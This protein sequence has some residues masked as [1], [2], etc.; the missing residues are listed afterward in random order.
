MEDLVARLRAADRLITQRSL[1]FAHADISV[2]AVPDVIAF[3]G[4]EAPAIIDWKVH[5]FG[6]RDAWLQL[7][8]VNA[9]TPA[10]RRTT[11]NFAQQFRTRLT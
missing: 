10:A 9:F 8:G 5:A 7:A 2:R 1:T 6:W 3:K 4:D 11:S